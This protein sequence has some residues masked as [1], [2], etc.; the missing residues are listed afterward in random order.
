M[1]QKIITDQD[2]IVFIH[3]EAHFTKIDSNIKDRIIECEKWNCT[4]RRFVSDRYLDGL[5]ET[6]QCWIGQY[7]TD[8]S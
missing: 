6:A 1:L 2:K 3:T 4:K 7:V 5:A 8:S